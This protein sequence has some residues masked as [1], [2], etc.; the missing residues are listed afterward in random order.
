[1]A[2][3]R[4]ALYAPDMVMEPAIQSLAVALSRKRSIVVLTG[5]GVS[6]ESGIPTFRDALT[7]Y[8]AKFDPQELATPEAFER[9]P[10]EVS[11]WYD[12]R[13]MRCRDARPNPAHR[14]LAQWEAL[15]TA[16]GGRFTLITQNV[17]RLHQAAGNRTIVELHGSLWVW[18]CTRCSREVEERGPAFTEFPPRCIDCGGPRRPGVVW[19]GEFLAPTVIRDAHA[20]LA[21]C[22]LFVSIGTSA[23]VHPAASFLAEA[24]ANGAYTLE[25]NLDATPASATVDQALF[26]KAGEI[27]PRL[28]GAIEA[29]G[30]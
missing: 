6:A 10:E 2:P 9:N 20:A 29:A 14:A 26:G 22:D 5:A 25:I 1:M 13:R 24:R 19:F 7:G 18:R 28:V 12:E 17:D 4:E 21:D 23:V 15:Q 11:R 16:R 27:L 30:A 3:E 8:W